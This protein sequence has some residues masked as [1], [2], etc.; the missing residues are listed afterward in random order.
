M[1]RPGKSGGRKR[2]GNLALSN[3]NLR[4]NKWLRGRLYSAGDNQHLP[5]N[6]RKCFWIGKIIKWKIDNI[7]ARRWQIFWQLY[8]PY[9]HFALYINTG[10]RQDLQCIPYVNAVIRKTICPADCVGGN[11]K[12][13]GDSRNCI[14]F[15]NC[16][17]NRF[18]SRFLGNIVW[19]TFSPTNIDWLDEGEFK[20]AAVVAFC[21][22]TG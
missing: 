15:L 14:S 9:L 6:Q 5:G 21:E 4:L 18:V 2:S 19:K 17:G 13:L 20:L 10:N 7:F 16:V 11:S 12:L 22:K 1:H 3:I 8:I